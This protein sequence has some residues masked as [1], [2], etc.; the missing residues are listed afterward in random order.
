MNPYGNTRNVVFSSIIEGL[1]CFLLALPPIYEND[2]IPELYLDII[3]ICLFLIGLTTYC[4]K[5]YLDCKSRGHEIIVEPEQSH[6]IILDDTV[7]RSSHD[8]SQKKKVLDNEDIFVNTIQPLNYNRDPQENIENTDK[9]YIKESEKKPSFFTFPGN[10]ASYNVSEPKK[11][12]EK[13]DNLVKP[14]ESNRSSKISESNFKNFLPR[15][16]EEDNAGSNRFL[17]PSNNSKNVNAPNL[18][19]S[20]KT[21][22]IKP[23]ISLNDFTVRSRRS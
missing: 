21:S 20:A 18:L 5:T 10:S 9:K 6:S 13:S 7:N 17:S 1:E 19:S 3:C 2:L 11:S 4:T 8:I 14:L 15:F 22:S 16:E 12:V 23:K